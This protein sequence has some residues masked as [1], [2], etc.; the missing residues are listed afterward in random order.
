LLATGTVPA[1]DVMIVPHH[2]SRTS[3][4]AEF[5][6]AT[7][8][9]WVVYAVG[10]RNRWNFPAPRVVERWAAAGAEARSSSHSGALTFELRPGSAL[11]APQEWRL[12]RQRPWLDP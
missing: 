5:V 12:R 9:R 7:R 10:Y 3:S 4:T 6:A 1:I 11:A 2:G 8:P